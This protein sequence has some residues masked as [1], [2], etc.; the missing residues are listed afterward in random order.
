MPVALTP[1]FLNQL[2][3]GNNSPNTIIE[4]TLDDGVRKFGFD[5][6][7][8]LDVQPILKNV[9]A[10]QNRI[11]AGKGYSSRGNMIF[12]I[13]GRETI[14]RLVSGRFLDNRRVCRKDGFY[15]TKTVPLEDELGNYLLDESGNIIL[16]DAGYDDYA[17]TYQGKIVNWKR[18]G[19]ELTIEVQDDL[20]EAFKKIPVENN[21]KT[22][23]LDYS[24]SNP[25]DI[26]TDMLSTQLGISSVYIDST[27]FTSERD[28]WLNNVVFH[29]IL[30]RPQKAD[31]FLNELQNETNSFVVHDGKQISYK[32]FSPI[33]P[34]QTL[35]GWTDNGNILENSVS[36]DSGYKDQMFNRIIVML[37][38]DESGNDKWQNYQTIYIN[39]DSSSLSTSE[40]DETNTREIKS[41]WMRTRGWTQPTNI[42]GVTVYHASIDNPVGTGTLTF[43]STG[44][45]STYKTLTWKAT[46]FS[47]DIPGD[48]VNVAS[49]GQFQLFDSDTSKS[50]RVVV[51]SSSLPAISSTD[52]IS[53]TQLNGQAYAQALADRHLS[54][55]RDPVSSIRFSLDIN[56]GSYN[57][58][59]IKPTDLKTITTDEAFDK[60]STSWSS[61]QMMLT[62]VRF[63]PESF[64]I[65]LEAIQT[66]LRKNYGFIAPASYPDYSSATDAQKEYAFIADSSGQLGGS[67]ALAYY[68]W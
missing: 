17:I 63:D 32:V 4:L 45:A 42:T 9:S 58:F 68:I 39:Q 56:D 65:D 3:Q 1:N 33:L 66:R 60:D 67:T 14:K 47:T 35:Q 12:T 7:G 54:R 61:E 20:S 26:I 22:Q 29:R 50:I 59:F 25:A 24:N 64:K 53:L 48:A 5:N 27:Q 46:S 8:F 38:Y 18:D 21:R 6:G 40:W 41:K 11:E 57:G 16:T 31:D 51:E 2:K 15:I 19:D 52:A 44:S 34:G 37:D 43:F 62:S 49:P 55:Y 10:L 13:S 30:T 28:T 36:Q 23:Y